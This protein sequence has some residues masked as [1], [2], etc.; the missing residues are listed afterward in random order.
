MIGKL[1]MRF[2]DRLYIGKSIKHPE[3]VKWKLRVVAGQF[4]VH[5]ITIS[6]NQ[7]N[8]LECFHNSLL[9]Q[10]FFRRQ[11]LL[12]VGIAGDYSEALEV[13]TQITEECVNTNGNADI[14]AFLLNEKS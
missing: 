2:H 12:V 7:D 5:L 8:Q 1:S 3:L 14:K 9:K 10:R 6:N 11:N 13:I 4:H